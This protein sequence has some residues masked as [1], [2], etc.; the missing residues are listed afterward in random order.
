MNRVFSALLICFLVS[1]CSSGGGA[2]GGGAGGGGGGS[3]A[4]NTSNS[5]GRV[6]LTWTAPAGTVTG[7]YV[8]QSIDNTNFTQVASVATTSTTISSLSKGTRY[9][10]RIRAYNSGGTSSYSATASAVP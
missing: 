5:G 4:N 8:E 2:G 10:F 7:Y 6:Q 3:S 9:Y 1:A